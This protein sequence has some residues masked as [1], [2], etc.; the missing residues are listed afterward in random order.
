MKLLGRLILVFLLSLGLTPLT[1][2][3]DAK[4][5][6]PN[7][8]GQGC[9]KTRQCTDGADGCVPINGGNSGG[10]YPSG[11]FLDGVD[12]LSHKCGYRPCGLFQC[13]CGNGNEIFDV[14][15]KK[16]C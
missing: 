9:P 7:I 5:S 16:D 13:Y 1:T 8:S 6:Q 3:D 2:A 14:E 4:P 12:M 11:C 10:Y 15:C